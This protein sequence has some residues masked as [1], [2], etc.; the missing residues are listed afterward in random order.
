MPLQ[1][2]LARELSKLRSQ[3]RLPPKYLLSPVR[4]RDRYPLKEQ[5]CRAA[6]S[7]INFS[8]PSAKRGRSIYADEQRMKAGRI[9][10]METAGKLRKQKVKSS[11]SEDGK[12]VRC[13]D[14]KAIGRYTEEAGIE[15]MANTRSAT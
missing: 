1:E 7:P 9:S 3:E 14:K 12:D 5:P 8:K 2:T 6:F 4:T 15:S 10:E 13:I 11:Q